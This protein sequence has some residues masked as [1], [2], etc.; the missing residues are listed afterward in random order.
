MKLQNA[1]RHEFWWA[2]LVAHNCIGSKLSLST[3][4]PWDAGLKQHAKNPLNTGTSMMKYTVTL[5]AL[6]NHVALCTSVY[7]YVPLSICPLPCSTHVTCIF[8]CKLCI[9]MYYLCTP[10]YYLC[11]PMYPCVLPC[12]QILCV[13]QC[14]LC[15]PPMQTAVS[16]WVLIWI[17]QAA[18]LN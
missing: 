8:S 12:M 9:T 14:T 17:A 16:T 2:L 7:T 15:S 18:I 3:V 5:Y 13:Y 10:M 1:C 4:L 11:T 6:S